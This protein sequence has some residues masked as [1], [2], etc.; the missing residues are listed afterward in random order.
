MIS[1][2]ILPISYTAIL[3]IFTIKNSPEILWIFLG[4][5]NGC[6]MYTHV[7][8]RWVFFNCWSPL[9]MGNRTIRTT[10]RRMMM[11]Y[12]DA[13]S[14]ISI[15]FDFSP[16]FDAVDCITNAIISV[17]VWN[18]HSSMLHLINKLFMNYEDIKM[19]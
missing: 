18:E 1:N 4:E 19:T 10:C 17:E 14:L 11:P 15:L 12:V 6:H 13:N 16:F 7:P 3:Y 9:I 8:I 2:F 5:M